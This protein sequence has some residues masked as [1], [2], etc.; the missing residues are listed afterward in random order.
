MRSHERGAK[1]LPHD[2]MN[3]N[4]SRDEGPVVTFFSLEMSNFERNMISGYRYMI[5]QSDM[6]SFLKRYHIH[7][8]V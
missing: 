8:D 6:N 5:S 1:D 4:L 7:H 3:L 2:E